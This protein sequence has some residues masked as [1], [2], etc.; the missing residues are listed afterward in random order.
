[1][2]RAEAGR[3]QDLQRTTQQFRCLCAKQF[4][5][6]TIEVGDHSCLIDD[7]EHVWKQREQFGQ[8][9]GVRA[10][11]GSRTQT[12]RKRETW[13]QSSP[14]TKH[15]FHQGKD[16][17]RPESLPGDLVPLLPLLHYSTEAAD[18]TRRDQVLK[19]FLRNTSI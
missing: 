18:A 17:L 6:L 11:A 15:G 1:M 2:L 12:N 3:Y 9:L 4:L 14:A 13:Y 8:Q 5:G 16:S 10:S 19:P 7:Q